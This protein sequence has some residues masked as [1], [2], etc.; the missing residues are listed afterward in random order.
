MLLDWSWSGYGAKERA[1]PDPPIVANILDFGAQGDGKFDNSGPF[2]A[3]IAKA[4]SVGGGTVY[5]PTGRYLCTKRIVIDGN[6]V[7]L[8]GDGVEQTRILF[9]TSLSELDDVVIDG[10]P[11]VESPYSW[12]GGWLSINGT[13][14]GSDD[15]STFIGAVTV[16]QPQ[17]SRTL[18]LSSTAG[19]QVGQWVRLMMSDVNGELLSAMYGSILSKVDCGSGKDKEECISTIQGE[20]DLVRWVVRIAGINGNDIT[21]QRALPVEVDP[22]WKAEIHRIPDSVV[23]EAGIRDLGVEFPWT[24]AAPH[25]KEKGYNAIFVNSAV[26]AFVTN[27]AAI[28]ADVGFMVA[29]SALVSIDGA[30]VGVTAPRGQTLPF[31]GHIGFGAY[32]SSDVE[33]GNWQ[34]NGMWTHDLTVRGT[35]M[36]V[37]HNGRGHN[38]NLDSHRSAPFATLYSNIN[39]GQGTRPYGTG[40]YLTQGLPSAKFTTYYN[41]RTNKNH[42][43]SLPTTTMSGNCTWG[44]NINALGYWTGVGCPGYHIE[45]FQY[46][47]LQPR[48]LYGSMIDRKYSTRAQ[49]GQPAPTDAITSTS[50]SGAKLQTKEISQPAAAGDGTYPVITAPEFY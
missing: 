26:N 6:G 24:P 47:T 10:A 4:K 44:S 19:I 7:V 28:N 22:T 9:P 45:T 30:Y 16:P 35:L 46:G 23:R 18:T 21:L 11:G 48:D 27:V 17:G 41:L 1:Y 8:K 14:P 25:L 13:D 50:T 39:M 20:K 49:G 34:I 37:F 5:V 2:A 42:A 31:D 12:M 32:D 36:T 33:I 3:A 15:Q 43:L 40:G 38:I 29:H